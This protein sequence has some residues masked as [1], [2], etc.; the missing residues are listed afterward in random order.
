[1]YIEYMPQALLEDI[2][3]N[4]CIPFIGAGFTRNAVCDPS[5]DILDWNGLGKKISIT[6]LHK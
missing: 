1:M 6:T 5:I 3:N 4:K 2:V